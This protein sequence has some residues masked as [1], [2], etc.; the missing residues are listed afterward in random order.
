LFAGV[1]LVCQSPADYVNALAYI[2]RSAGHNVD[3]ADS[4]SRGTVEHD[5]SFQTKQRHRD[6]A[7]SLA[8]YG[9]AESRHPDCARSSDNEC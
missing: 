3:E 6:F 4:F 1:G 5:V 9:W 8:G 7:G 2:G